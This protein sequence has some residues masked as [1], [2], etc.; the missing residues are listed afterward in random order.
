MTKRTFEAIK[1]V[2]DDQAKIYFCYE[3]K[4]EECKKKY[5]TLKDSGSDMTS[6]EI[7]ESI[8][9]WN[10]SYKC[11]KEAYAEGKKSEEN[12]KKEIDKE[13]D[14]KQVFGIMETTR[15]VNIL[16]L[17]AVE[18]I[19]KVEDKLNK[20]IAIMQTNNEKL[21]IPKQAEN[22]VKQIKDNKIR[23]ESIYGELREFSQIAAM[24]LGKNEVYE[25]QFKCEICKRNFTIKGALN[26]HVRLIHGESLMMEKCKECR[27]STKR[28]YDLHR[29]VDA[30]HKDVIHKCKKCPKTF[31]WGKSLKRHEKGVH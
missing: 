15:L 6:N 29:H 24:E 25:S 3:L 17:N 5:D 18:N 31:K 21:R 16:L 7:E 26:K 1:K 22:L 30:R 13:L 10:Y 20:L 4:N 8:V 2:I 9:I 11:V 19:R 27:Y 23:I 28:L 12:F 14:I